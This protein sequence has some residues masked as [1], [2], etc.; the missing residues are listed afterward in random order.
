MRTITYDQFDKICEDVKELE[1]KPD[2][3]FPTVKEIKENIEPN[4]YKML[5]LRFYIQ[6]DFSLLSH[7]PSSPK[8]H[9]IH[10]T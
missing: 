10:N 8:T 4:I 2:G 3:W 9:K 1:F 7:N 6:F 5:N